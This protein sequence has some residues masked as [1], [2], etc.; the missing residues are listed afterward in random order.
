MANSYRPKDDFLI[1]F[2][3]YDYF[4]SEKQNIIKLAHIIKLDELAT[5]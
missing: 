2:S 3:A 5:S 1:Y 4:H